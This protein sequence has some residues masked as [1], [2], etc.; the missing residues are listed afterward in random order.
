MPK[1][2]I[3]EMP[4]LLK[5]CDDWIHH[6]IDADDSVITAPLATHSIGVRV[7]WDPAKAKTKTSTEAQL[8]RRDHFPP[9]NQ[10]TMG[11]YNTH[12]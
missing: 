11:M 12:G 2:A 6:P 4:Q 3:P 8:A 7:A 1:S 10:L 5:A 9:V